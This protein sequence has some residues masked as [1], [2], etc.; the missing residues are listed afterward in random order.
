MIVIPS[1]VIPRVKQHF[2]HLVAEAPGTL[3]KNLVYLWFL[4]QRW[5]FLFPNGLLSSPLMYGKELM[6]IL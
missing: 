5:N 1:C 2:A 6:L 4:H 3:C